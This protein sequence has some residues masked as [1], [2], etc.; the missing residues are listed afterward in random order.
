M[1]ER[2]QRF[3]FGCAEFEM[4]NGGG[5]WKNLEFRV[6]AQA[7]DIQLGI[8]VERL[9]KPLDWWS[10]GVRMDGEGTKRWASPVWRLGR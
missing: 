9:L 4:E 8:A 3:G 7:V 5:I 2:N 1:G 10:L 6:K